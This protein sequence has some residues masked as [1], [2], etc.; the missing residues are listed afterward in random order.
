MGVTVR[1][2][3]RRARVLAWF[4]KGAGLPGEL[5]RLGHAGRLIPPA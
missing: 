2:A 5:T 3:L 1:R 4:A